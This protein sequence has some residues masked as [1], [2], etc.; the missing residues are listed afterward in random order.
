MYK[1]ITVGA[2][3]ISV[4]NPLN[5]SACLP[6]QRQSSTEQLSCNHSSSKLCMQTHSMSESK[7]RGSIVKA[8]STRPELGSEPGFHHV[9]GNP[10]ETPVDI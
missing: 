3:I 9:D 5:S 10:A 2:T 1:A 7:P 8:L 4:I 6:G